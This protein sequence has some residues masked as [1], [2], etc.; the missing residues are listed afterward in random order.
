MAE[1]SLPVIAVN[2]NLFM[3]TIFHKKSIRASRTGCRCRLHLMRMAD[4]FADHEQ[5]FRRRNEDNTPHQIY[6]IAENAV[7]VPPPLF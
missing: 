4:G 7:D 3:R 6:P 1:L 5:S 2:D